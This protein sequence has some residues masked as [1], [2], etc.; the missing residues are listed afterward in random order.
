MLRK[1]R[2]GWF[3]T[4]GFAM[5]SY[6]LA[7][8]CPTLVPQHVGVYVYHV[9]LLA[10]IPIALEIFVPTQDKETARPANTRNTEPRGSYSPLDIFFMF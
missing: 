3:L 10:D 2:S 9:H 1:K 8:R 5:Y 6:S 7:P 4:Y